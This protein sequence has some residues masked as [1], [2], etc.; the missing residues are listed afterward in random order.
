M[1]IRDRDNTH[2]R[3]S[4]AVTLVGH[5]PVHD[6]TC[7]YRNGAETH[8]HQ[9]HFPNLHL[10][11]WLTTKLVTRLVWCLAATNFNALLTHYF[12]GWTTLFTLSIA[13]STCLL[14]T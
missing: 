9:P 5:G 1:C 2:G 10:T 3:E 13:S 8:S 12:F 11:V 4:E 6:R 7:R 14:Y